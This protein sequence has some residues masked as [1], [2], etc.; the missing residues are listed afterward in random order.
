MVDANYNFIYL[1]VGANGRSNDAGIF[2]ESTL[3]AALE[4]GTIHLPPNHIILGDSAFPLKKY[5]MKPYT[6]R[7]KTTK[8]HIYSITDFRVLAV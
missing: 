4:G 6:N 8:Q 7:C 5:P 3:Y 2:N 1:N